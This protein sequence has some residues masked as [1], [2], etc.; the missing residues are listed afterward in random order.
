MQ[1]HDSGKRHLDN[2]TIMSLPIRLLLM[3]S[4][5]RSLGFWS[6][7]PKKHTPKALKPKPLAVRV[8]IELLVVVVALA[9]LPIR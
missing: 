3:E 8:I 5:R 7:M 1:V 9:W 2:Q 4:Q 6:V